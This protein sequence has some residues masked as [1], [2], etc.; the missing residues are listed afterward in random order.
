MGEGDKRS[1]GPGPRRTAQHKTGEPERTSE[2]P[3]AAGTAGASADPPNAHGAELDAPRTSRTTTLDDPL[4]TSLLAE[5]ARRSRTIDVSPEQIAE[6]TDIEP[7]D[8]AGADAIGS[9]R[10]ASREPTTRPG[11]ARTAVPDSS[12]DPDDPGDPQAPVGP[13]PR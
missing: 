8:L 11:P 2:K 4:T 9:P 5:V 3:G 13:R 6:A 12:E 10:N 1:Q 7:A